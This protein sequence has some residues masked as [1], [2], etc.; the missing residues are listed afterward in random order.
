MGVLFKYASVFGNLCANKDMLSCSLLEKNE[1]KYGMFLDLKR[2]SS[3]NLYK[4]VFL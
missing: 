4:I 1:D 2:L 3:D